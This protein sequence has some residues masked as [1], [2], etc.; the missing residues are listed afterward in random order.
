M[1]FSINLE[2]E[3]GKKTLTRRNIG[4]IQ[5][6]KLLSYN[7]TNNTCP[8]FFPQLMSTSVNVLRL[9]VNQHVRKCMNI[10]PNSQQEFSAFECWL[11]LQNIFRVNI[12]G[13][14]MCRH[15]RKY[16]PA[17]DLINRRNVTHY[18]PTP[19]VIGISSGRS[20][21]TETLIN[22]SAKSWTLSL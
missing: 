15:I 13:V 20:T 5:S 12:Y 11:I 8:T 10:S 3:S 18:T 21:H 22:D 14:H 2:S 7:Q 16:R 9:P 17:N 19:A 6:S 4:T 1:L